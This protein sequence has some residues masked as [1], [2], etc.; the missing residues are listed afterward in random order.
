[1]AYGAKY[2]LEFSDVQG[3][4]RKI[5]ILKKDYN[6]T[7]FPMIC[8]GEPMTIEWK[9][10]DDIYEPLIGSSATLNLK[11]TNDV[12]YDN[13]F[14]YDEREYKLILYFQESVG[15][16]SIYWAGF[17][18]NDVYQ[19][20]IIT[21]PYNI[22][23][24]AI[25]GLGQLKGFNTWLPDT[26]TD[27]KNTFL[28]E[29]IYENLGQLG[30]DFDIWLSNDIRDG[31]SGNWSNI[32][33]DLL[34][35]TN[36]FITKDNDILDAK[37]VLRSILI[38]TNVRI[39]QSYGR[40][41]IVNCSS[42]GDQRI[43]EGIQSGALVG[44]AI[45]PAKQAYLNG[46]SEN[47]KFYIY[48]SSGTNLSNTTANY[49]RTIK[50]QLIPRNSNMV[51]SVKRPLKKYEM[52]VDL[53]NKQVYANYNAGFEFG[54]QYWN[55]GG[56]V[57]LTVGSDFSANGANSVS[58]TNYQS[59]GGYT[60]ST[61]ITCQT[62]NVS[63]NQLTLNFNMD[64]AFDNYNY[65]GNTTFTY[66][67]A[68]YVR[69]GTAG[70]AYF[71]AATNTWDVTG[72]IIWNTQTVECQS[73]E[74]RNINVGLPSLAV[75]GDL[76]VGVAVP[77]YTGFGFN[78]T[79]IDNVGLIQNAI[80]ASRF[81]AVTYT[82]TLYNNNKSDLLEHDGIYNYNSDVMDLQNDSILYNAKYGL[83]FGLKRAQDTTPQKMEQ[84]V[85]QQ[86]L[87]DFRAFLKCYEGDFSINGNNF[88]LS[89]ANKVYIKFDTFTETDSAIMDSMKFSV[90]SNIYSIICHIPDNYTD[91][92]HQYRVIFQV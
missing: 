10:D 35:K 56:G 11:V 12:T 5:E 50:S 53:E 7:V 3:N 14:E 33:E 46:G 71:N 75:Y 27:P 6:S 39:F 80:G 74:F 86:R 13:F 54:L 63:S 32:Y 72:T 51:R 34:I 55:A 41:Y 9:A 58:F 87:N 47:I 84:I 42:Y 57:T 16:W 70:S 29:F 24:T 18:T 23:L 92:S 83:S 48:N 20:A 19:E 68:Y 64:V 15:V 61:A 67:I 60:P 69:G 26:L 30:L 76:L 28:W 43:I 31:I 82:G 1:M 81:K 44:N 22:E 45:L 88:M 4:Q 90:K 62:F 77:Y 49:L 79:Y 85:I 21:P 38:A 73:F 91:V 37:K 25:D 17:I 59:S 36:A 65:D 2:R 40:W 89:M 66:Q 8:D 78:K 52:T